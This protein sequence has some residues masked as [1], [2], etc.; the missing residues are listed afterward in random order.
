MKHESRTPR[1]A[2]LTASAALAAAGVLLPSNAFA[3]QA[4]PQANTITAMAPS[5]D[6]HGDHG[7]DWRYCYDRHHG[8][9]WDWNWEWG[10]GYCYNQHHHQHHG[11]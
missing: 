8:W 6:G 7:Y 11:R 1:L 5:H 2:V 10:W 3:A 9:S 4:A